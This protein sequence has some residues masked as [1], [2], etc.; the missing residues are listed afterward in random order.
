LQFWSHAVAS[1][2]VGD[3]D[4]FIHAAPHLTFV[5]R[6]G[7]IRLLKARQAALVKHHFF[8]TMQYTADAHTIAGWVPLVMEERPAEP[9]AATR[10]DGGPAARFLDDLRKAIVS[11]P[12]S[13]VA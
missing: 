12:P 8:R 10:V 5:H 7:D 13:L 1:G 9:V 6:D 2:L 3:P 11:L 4:E